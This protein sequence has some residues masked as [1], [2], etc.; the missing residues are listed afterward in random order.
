MSIKPIDYKIL[1][2]KSQEISRIKQVEN[3]KFK[4]QIRQGVLQ[5]D[6]QVEKNTKRVRDTNKSENITVDVNKK[7]K[8][9]QGKEKKKQKEEENQNKKTKIKDSIG[10]TI[11]I[12]I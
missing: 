3:D 9:G 5:Q 12:K 11:D 1:V 2:P 10:G 7:K 4:N 8:D 6:K